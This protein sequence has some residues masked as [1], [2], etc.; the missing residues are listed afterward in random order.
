MVLLWPAFSTPKVT[1]PRP[2][3]KKMK[4]EEEEE[5]VLLYLEG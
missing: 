3:Q 4:E 5:E 1:A 2:P